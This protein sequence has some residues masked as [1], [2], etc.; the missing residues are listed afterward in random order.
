[1]TEATPARSLHPVDSPTDAI[2]AI[3]HR[4]ARRL[5]GAALQ[6]EVEA[7]LSTYGALRDEHG[8]RAV[9]R[10]GHLPEREVQTG[11]G[12]VTVERYGV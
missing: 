6:S 11:I 5:L 12:A 2:T 4:G 8:H 3:L 10:N 9:V 7:F 1:M